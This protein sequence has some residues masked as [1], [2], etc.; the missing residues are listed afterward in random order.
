MRKLSKRAELILSLVVREYIST[1]QPV[2]SQTLVQKYKLN[3]S[4]ATVRNEMALLEAEG[5]LTHPHTSAGRVPT[6][7]GYRCFVEKLLETYP[8]S[9]SEKL[10]IQHQFYQV[11]MDVEQWGRLAASV[12][13]RFTNYPAVVTAPAPPR[14]RLKH[15]DLIPYRE[16][17]V[18][19][20]LVLSGGVIKQAWFPVPYY[21]GEPE[22][23]R[24]TEI[25]EEFLYGLSAPEIEGI[26]SRLEPF[27]SKIALKVA[28]IMNALDQRIE[29]P[30]YCEGIE[31][32]T[33]EPEFSSPVKFLKLVRFF[34]D[35][36]C[37]RSIMDEIRL[38]NGVQIIIGGEGRWEELKDCS[39]VLARYGI[40]EK[41]SGVLGVLGPMRMAYERAI[42]VVSYV[43]NLMSEMVNTLF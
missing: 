12:L 26:A 3:I 16:N 20:V 32:I 10:T 8:L 28:E 17:A 42:S 14:Y 22:L 35:E 38:A 7:K 9:P 31:E 19:L 30:I 13:A 5:Y 25:L 24:T 2:G 4:P 36:S 41:A 6:E 21:I 40:R 27:A 23:I 29:E 33:R 18:L 43:A 15:I 1:A 11:H 39:M 37:L 34:K